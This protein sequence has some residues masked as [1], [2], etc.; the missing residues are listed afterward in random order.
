MDEKTLLILG[1]TG[2]FFSFCGIALKICFASKCTSVEIC[3][4]KIKRNVAIE[5]LYYEN[6]TDIDYKT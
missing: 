3:C 5:P 1:L 6:K 2:M 4:I